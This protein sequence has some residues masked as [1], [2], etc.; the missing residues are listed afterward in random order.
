MDAKLILAFIIVL[1]GE[2]L[3]QPSQIA[4]NISLSP[5][6]ISELDEGDVQT[7][8]YNLT[9]RGNTTWCMYMTQITVH[10]DDS[11]IA[12]IQENATVELDWLILPEYAMAYGS[13]VVKG[14]RLGKT[15]IYFYMHPVGD[16]V[17]AAECV[18]I[19]KDNDYEVDI[20]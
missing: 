20:S 19:L 14:T 9:C 7:V 11:R 16:N 5:D 6:R 1:I 15:F 10:V 2:L 13:F 8:K 17:E 3:A 12:Q 4:Y 18:Q